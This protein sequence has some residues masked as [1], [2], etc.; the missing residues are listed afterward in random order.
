MSTQRTI[1][2]SGS[3]GRLGSRLAAGFLL[4]GDQVIGLDRSPRTGG[5]WPVIQMDATDEHSVQRAFEELESTYSTPNAVI[6]TVGMWAMSPFT[7]TSLDEWD[8]LLKLNL[9][10]SFLVYRE[11]VRHMGSSGGT[12]IGITSRQGAVQGAA[13][14]A[15]YSAAKGGLVRLIESIAAEFGASGICAHAL[16]PS[17]ILFGEE[18]EGV[19]AA[20]LVSHCK[21]RV[22]QAGVSLNG[23]ILSAYG[24]G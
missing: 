17:T 6:H 4:G 24:N 10:S 3:N 15:G 7:E 21:Y 19:Q 18:G 14:Q 23:Q 22:S 1:V 5:D 20:D 13:G 2:I 9:T 11:A 12:L 8:V 16:A